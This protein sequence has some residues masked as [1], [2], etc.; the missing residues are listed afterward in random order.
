MADESKG[1]SM[2]D[3]KKLKSAIESMS[4]PIGDHVF[5]G[6]SVIDQ[7]DDHWEKLCESHP[8]LKDEYQPR[9]NAASNDKSP[10]SSS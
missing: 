5:I 6:Q 10:D 1:L 2:A 3:F 9:L 7:M 8:K 4:Q